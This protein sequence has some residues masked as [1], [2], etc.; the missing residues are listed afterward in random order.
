MGKNYGHK[1]YRP[2]KTYQCKYI[3]ILFAF[4]GNTTVCK[5]ITL[6]FVFLGNITV[7]PN[8]THHDTKLRIRIPG[9]AC[10]SYSGAYPGEPKKMIPNFDK[11]AFNQRFIPN[12]C[13]HQRKEKTCT[14]GLHI[15]ITRHGF[16]YHS[17]YI[18]HIT[19]QLNHH[20]QARACATRLLACLSSAPNSPWIKTLNRR[21]HVKMA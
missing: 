19:F 15:T 6:L 18:K 12:F 4:L 8:E 7:I 11:T 1:T 17:S 5:Y 14:P 10:C 2:I 16:K 3:T 13:I 20:Q 21:L 9:L